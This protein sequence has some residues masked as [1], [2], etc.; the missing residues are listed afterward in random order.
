MF[1]KSISR[2][3]FVGGASLATIA[4]LAGCSSSSS[5]TSSSTSSSSTSADR[6]GS[7]YWLNFKPE[8]DATAQDLASKYMTATVGGSSASVA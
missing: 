4:G 8:L 7:V 5:G 3:S 6:S 1:G 2:R